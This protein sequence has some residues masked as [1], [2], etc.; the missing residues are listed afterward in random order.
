MSKYFS[1]NEL[2]CTHCGNLVFDDL[3]LE[4]LDDIREEC[5]FALPVSSG[6]RCPE[7][8]IEAEKPEPGAHCSGQAV[9]I[10]VSGW[11]AHRLLEVAF[12][13]GIVRVGVNQDGPHS[14]R[15]IHLDNCR[16]LPF[17]AVWSY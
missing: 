12:K 3:F 11:K 7:H 1:H 17:P 4:I 13:H 2:K 8:P 9:D 10:Q 14:K 16:D 5:G 6:Y 15:F